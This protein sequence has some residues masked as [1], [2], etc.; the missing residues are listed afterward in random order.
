MFYCAFDRI[1]GNLNLSFIY[2]KYDKLMQNTVQTLQYIYEKL[3]YEFI[4]T[5]YDVEKA[6]Q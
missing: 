4:E 1:G 6:I 3:D 5:S 2:I